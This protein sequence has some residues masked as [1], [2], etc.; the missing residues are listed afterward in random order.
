M[1]FGD[2]TAPLVLVI[3]LGALLFVSAICSMVQA[4]TS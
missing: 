4:V 3:G 1:S 2:E